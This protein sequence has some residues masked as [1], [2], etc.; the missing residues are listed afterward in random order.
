MWFFFWKIEIFLRSLNILT[1]MHVSIS[2]QI[3]N[4]FCDIVI[5]SSGLGSKWEKAIYVVYISQPFKPLT[6]ILN[7]TPI[8]THDTGTGIDSIIIYAF[9]RQVIRNPRIRQIPKRLTDV[10]EGRDGDN[11]N[12]LKTVY[13]QCTY[14]ITLRVGGLNPHTFEQNT[15]TPIRSIES[16][17]F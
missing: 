2:F 12:E 1:L 13:V 5:R 16:L 7:Q 9:K 17:I 14:G 10:L 3:P 15:P 4:V 6:K 11:F 8:C